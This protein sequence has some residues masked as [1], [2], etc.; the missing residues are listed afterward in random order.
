MD[1]QGK[2]YAN[3]AARA[4]LEAAM[5]DKDERVHPLVD[6]PANAIGLDRM[7]AQ[8]LAG[9]NRKQRMAFYSEKRRGASLDEAFEA[10]RR[11]LPYR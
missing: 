8:A 5:Q 2:I 6:K 4:E 11:A 1:D 3:E 9:M 10:A 7:T